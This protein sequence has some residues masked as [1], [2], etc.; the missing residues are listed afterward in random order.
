MSARNVEYT[1]WIRWITSNCVLQSQR[2]CSPMCICSPSRQQQS[3]FVS[4]I[5]FFLGS[6]SASH[7]METITN[8]GYNAVSPLRLS[9][10]QG[11]KNT[12][13]F[14]SPRIMLSFLSPLE[15]SSRY[16]IGGVRG[17]HM[18]RRN[19]VWPL[20]LYATEKMSFI[21]R[22]DHVLHSAGE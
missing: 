9:I 2:S 12:F 18:E 1:V 8:A 16:F 14:G 6:R 21:M 10:V 19:H 20:R 17:A 5:S 11:K 4:F 3:I 13:L 7:R 15:L 22:A